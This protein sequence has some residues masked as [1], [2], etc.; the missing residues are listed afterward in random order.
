MALKDFSGPD[1]LEVAVV[2]IDIVGA[3]LDAQFEGFVIAHGAGGEGEVSC[4]FEL[5]GD[6]TQLSECAAVLREGVTQLGDS[7]VT[8]VGDA[9][10]HHGHAV[11]RI[12]F[13]EDLLEGCSVL[14]FTGAAADGALDVVLGHVLGAGLVHGQA[15]PEVAVGISAAV[16]GGHDELARE[17]GEDGAALGIRGALLALDGGPLGMTGHGDS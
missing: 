8:V 17:P 12:A 2:L 4:A 16:P 11:G 6:G 9:F 1:D 15:Q 13:I 5:P 14:V 3:G 10:D 7:P